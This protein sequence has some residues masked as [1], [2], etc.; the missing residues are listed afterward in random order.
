MNRS[1]TAE[2]TYQVNNFEPVRLSDSINDLPDELALNNDLINKIRY[3]QF[4]NIEMNYR[5]YLI[6]VKKANSLPIE[7]AMAFLE[8]E[9]ATTLEDIKSIIF[10]KE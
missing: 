7:E 4:L 1:L 9:K 2:R 6:I 5:E 8:Q 3:L 10:H